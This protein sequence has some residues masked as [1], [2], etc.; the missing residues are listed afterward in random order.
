MLPTPRLCRNRRVRTRPNLGS[1][2]GPDREA[3]GKGGVRFG[4]PRKLTPEAKNLARRG[5]GVEKVRQQ[6][7]VCSEMWLRFNIG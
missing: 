1:G 6:V 2:P 3:A 5:A 7:P 4:R